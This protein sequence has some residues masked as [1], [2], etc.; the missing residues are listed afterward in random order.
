[1]TGLI[2]RIER[3]G[4]VERTSDPLDRRV[5]LLS[6]TPAG[7]KVREQIER[8]LGRRPSLFAGLEP[9]DFEHLQRILRTVAPAVDAG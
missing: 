7:R 5:R 3:L 4:L 8:E 9:A 6:L 1:V 2:D